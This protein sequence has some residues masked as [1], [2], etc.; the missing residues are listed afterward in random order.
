MPKAKQKEL[1]PPTSEIETFR[2]VRGW[3]LDNLVEQEPSCWNGNVSVR[4]FRV[5]AE[6]IEEPDEV[7]I[8]RIQKLWRECDNHY[9]WQ[10]LRNAAARYGITLDSK[11]CGK[12]KP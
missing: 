11:D 2:D 9:H 7:I 5:T 6:M 12:D 8:A 10:P 3:S 1:P 4:R